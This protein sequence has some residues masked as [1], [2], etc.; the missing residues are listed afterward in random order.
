MCRPW[1]IMG[2]PGAPHGAVAH[3]GSVYLRLGESPCR[4]ATSVFIGGAAPLE[5]SASQSIIP[6]ARG[7]QIRNPD[8]IVDIRRVDSGLAPE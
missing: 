7:A 4:F 1:R 8:N 5:L 2:A 6:D 3:K